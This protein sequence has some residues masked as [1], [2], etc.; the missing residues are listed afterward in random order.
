DA[1]YANTM[2][3]T[4]LPPQTQVT[5]GDML[6][7][8]N[9]SW[10]WYAGS[11]D[12]AVTDGMQDPATKRTVIYAGNSSGLATTANV[13]FQAHHHPFNY[14]AAFDPVAHGAD[15]SAHLKD[16]NKLVAD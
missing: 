14:Y 1:L 10:A 4:T 13:D 16:Y 6:N 3:A 9:V 11:W 15:R 7:A 5:I 8:K 12:A 2:S